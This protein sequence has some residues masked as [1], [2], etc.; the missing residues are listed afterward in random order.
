MTEEQHQRP[1]P[2]RAPI[3]DRPA[4]FTKG[5]WGAATIALGGLLVLLLLIL[6]FFLVD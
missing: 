5:S 4:R 3:E 6:A 2:D 1:T